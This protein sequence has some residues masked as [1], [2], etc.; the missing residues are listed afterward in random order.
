HDPLTG[1]ANRRCFEEA[2]AAA[3]GRGGEGH[4]V[5]LVYLDLDG[6]KLVN[7]TLGHAA[8]DNLL[9]Q[10]ASRLKAR[11]SLQRQRTTDAPRGL[12]ADTE[13][14]ARVGGDEF[15]VVVAGRSATRAVAPLAE[16]LLRAF[17][18]PFAIGGNEI[19]IGASVG[20]SRYPLD[21]G[22]AST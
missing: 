19:N 13:L 11:L 5:A 7:D 15:T 9:K 3:V 8:G 12:C 16:S 17:D 20:I 2:L 14:L 18:S 6:F 21:G 1:L 22:D 10:V 4:E